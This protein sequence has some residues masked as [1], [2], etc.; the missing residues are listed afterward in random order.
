MSANLSQFRWK[1]VLKAANPEV[2]DLAEDDLLKTLAP[3]LIG[4]GFEQ[5]I[6]DRAESVTLLE[7]TKPWSSQSR[8]FF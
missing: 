5:K 6:K 2:V 7:A 3:N 4:P 8:K 1:R